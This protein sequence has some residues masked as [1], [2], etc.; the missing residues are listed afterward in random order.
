MFEFLIAILTALI[1]VLPIASSTGLLAKRITKVR[2]WLISTMLAAAGSYLMLLATVKV[3]NVHLENVL[4]R[5]DLNRDGNF[6]GVEL[7]PSQEKAMHMVIS[8]TGRTFAPI[9]G[10]ITCP[11]YSL[12]WHTI[13]G[14]PYFLFTNHNRKILE[15]K[16]QSTTGGDPII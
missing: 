3:T 6:S 14:I 8:D 2:F 7:T 12:F 1:F 13:T 16:S 5:Y 10:L 15:K 4:N 11:I 9:L